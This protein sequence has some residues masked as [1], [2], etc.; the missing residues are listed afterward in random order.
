MTPEVPELPWKWTRRSSD[1]NVIA[2]VPTSVTR[3]AGGNVLCSDA[4]Q[5]HDQ[6]L[7]GSN[8]S[9]RTL[10]IRYRP[11]EQYKG[12]GLSSAILLER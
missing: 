10:V 9:K 6:R 3:P 4:R 8:R 12:V 11:S 2:V 7:F 5:I 1:R